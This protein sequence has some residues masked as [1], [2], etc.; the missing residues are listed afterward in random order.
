MAEPL[1]MRIRHSIDE[2]LIGRIGILLDHA[3]FSKDDVCYD[4]SRKELVIRLRRHSQASKSRKKF[5]WLTV[6]DNSIPPDVDCVLTVKAVEECSIRDDDPDNPLRQEI[7]SGGLG[8]LAK[9]TMY[10]G[11]YCH[12]E[13]PFGI[14]VHVERVDI[15]LEDVT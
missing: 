13:N 3:R 15:T 14:T 12:H 11:A 5:L 6:W 7:I 2:M 10:I 4:E 9:G 1:R 8:A